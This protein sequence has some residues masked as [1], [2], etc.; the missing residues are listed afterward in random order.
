LVK[1]GIIHKGVGGGGGGGKKWVPMREKIDALN[2][3]GRIR[4]SGKE[5]Y[6]GKTIKKSLR[7]A[8]ARRGRC[9][10][11][12]GART[13]CVWVCCDRRVRGEVKQ[14]VQRVRQKMGRKGVA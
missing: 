9:L 5:F 6:E 12:G 3:F 4:E 13:D 14:T 7:K 1:S 2:I 11:G 10:G 8:R